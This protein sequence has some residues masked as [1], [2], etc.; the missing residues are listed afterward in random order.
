MISNEDLAKRRAWLVKA[1]KDRKKKWKT[2]HIDLDF[3]LELLDALVEAY[4][5]AEHC[6]SGWQDQQAMY[7]SAAYLTFP[8]EEEAVLPWEEEAV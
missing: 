7:D 5:V 1:I 2:I 4:R 8:W 3:Q 6:R